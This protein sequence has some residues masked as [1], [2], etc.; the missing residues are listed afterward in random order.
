MVPGQATDRSRALEAF[1]AAR[2][3][4]VDNDR[5]EVAHEAVFA[6]WPRLAAWLVEDAA[7]R[8]VRAHL[9]PAAAVWEAEGRPADQLYRG[10]RLEAAQEWIERPDSDPTATEIAFVA[11]SKARSQA[12]LAEARARADAERAGRRRTR[13]L[14]LVLAATAVVALLAGVLALNGQR[15]AV[16]SSVLADADGLAAAS[17]TAPSPDLSMLLAVQANRIASTPQ[18]RDALL[19]SVVAHDH[20]QAVLQDEGIRRIAFGPDGHT[21]YGLDGRYVR[22]WDLAAP[23]RPPRQ[24]ADL[25][26][27]L[28]VPASL[29]VSHTGTVAVIGPPE[30]SGSGP[31]LRLIHP[32]GRPR[33]VPSNALNAWPVSV[34]LHPGRT[35]VGGRGIPRADR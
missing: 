18:T 9:A 22:A 12:E 8:A 29:A 13:N 10:A 35:A 33:V 11:A 17:L 26:N 23:H 5:A 15:K 27:D 28:G 31:T 24:I 20:M 3:V 32:Y 19:A 30:T 1:V 4:T 34:R 21:L 2:L 7:G 25:K 14:A 16:A 6:A